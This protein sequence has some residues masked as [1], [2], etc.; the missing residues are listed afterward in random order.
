VAAK[1]KAMLNRQAI[2]TSLVPPL[3]LPTHYTDLIDFIKQVLYKGRKVSSFF[4]E[5]RG[6]CQNGEK[7]ATGLIFPGRP[8]NTSP[9]PNK[10]SCA[11]SFLSLFILQNP[12][13]IAETS[14]LFLSY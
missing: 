5:I 3:P 6:I 14:R 8:V 11:Y 4:S 1:A 2:S 7:E 9:L 13:Q 12:C 10:S